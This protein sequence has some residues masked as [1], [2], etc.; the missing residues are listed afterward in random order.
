MSSFVFRISEIFNF[1]NTNAFLNLIELNLNGNPLDDW[2]NVMRFAHLPNLKTVYI[3]NC[4]IKSIQ[5]FVTPI[6]FFALRT[7]LT[8]IIKLGDSVNQTSCCIA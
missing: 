3:N 8:L 5:V 4:N 2:S 6:F 7:G 1:Q